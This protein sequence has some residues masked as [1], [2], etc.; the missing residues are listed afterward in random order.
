M[1]F[2]ALILASAPPADGQVLAGAAFERL[3]RKTDKTCKAR[4][5]RT[6]TPGDLDYIQEDFENSLPR[7]T[8]LRL[9]SVNRAEQ[10]C[11]GSNGLS[12]QTA[13][14]LEAFARSGLES[15]FASYICSHPNPKTSVTIKRR[16]AAMLPTRPL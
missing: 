13:A 6:I 9:K 12:C 11:S 16:D 14:T 2:L 7:A 3:A 4:K 15:S 10:K 8:Q 5:V 1:L